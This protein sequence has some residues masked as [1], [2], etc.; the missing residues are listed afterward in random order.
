MDCS[1]TLGIRNILCLVWFFKIKLNP[2][3]SFHW[4]ELVRSL[5]SIPF[6]HPSCPMCPRAHLGH[7]EWPIWLPFLSPKTKQHPLLALSMA[8]GTAA[9]QTVLL[10]N[11]LFHSPAC[12]W[13]PGLFNL[14]DPSH[15]GEVLSTEDQGFH[16]SK[17]KALSILLVGY[18]GKWSFHHFFLRLAAKK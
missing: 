16:N 10:S 17:Q 8:T 4:R 5:M 9:L 2:A 14:P 3:L 11:R 15:P 18:R 1:R 13:D 6:S 7:P 12:E